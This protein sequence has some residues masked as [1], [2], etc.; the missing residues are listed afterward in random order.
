MAK[1]TLHRLR[2]VLAAAPLLLAGCTGFGWQNQQQQQFNTSIELLQAGDVRRSHELL[3]EVVNAPAVSGVTD[4]ALFRLALLL[5]T[6]EVGGGRTAPRAQALLERLRKE[7]PESSWTPHASMLL[8]W[9]TS[10]RGGR[11]RDREQIN[12]LL[13]ENRELRQNLERLK[14]LDLELEKKRKR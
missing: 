9:L 13:R 1:V 12:H 3:E 4:E 7:Y 10:S 5:I 8:T 11:D 6:E 14:D 2:L